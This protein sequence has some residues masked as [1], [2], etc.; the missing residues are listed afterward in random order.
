MSAKATGIFPF[1]PN[2]VLLSRFVR[3]LDQDETSQQERRSIR[4]MARLDI[5]DKIITTPEE[6]RK[7]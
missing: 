3:D 7:I 4:R 6:L 2:V 1:E 5:N